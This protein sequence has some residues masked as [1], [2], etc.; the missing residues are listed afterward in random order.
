MRERSTW[1]CQEV[2]TKFAALK[3]A[4]PY[5]MNQEHPQPPWDKYVSGD[6]SA[7]A[8][9][10]HSP[11]TWETEY[12]DDQTARDEIG[13]PQVRPDTFNHTE[14]TASKEVLLK[15]ADLCI[16]VAQLMLKQASTEA[17]EDQAVA[18]MHLPDQELINT[19][20]RM[21][22]DED[23]DKDGDKEQEKQ[24]GQ[25]EDKKD[26]TKDQGQGQEKQAEEAKG[27]K[28]DQNEKSNKNWPAKTAGEMQQMA[29]QVIQQIQA[30][31]LAE[32]QEQI[33]QMVETAQQ[34][35]QA[36]AQAPAQ[37]QQQQAQQQQQS[38]QAQQQQVAQ[39][40]Q[41]MI[42]QAMQQQQAQQ[43]QAPVQAPAQAPVQDQQQQAQQQTPAQ[44]PVQDQQQ[45][46][47]QDAQVLDQM[48]AGCGL[49]EGDIQMDPAPMDVGV[50]D[51]GAED[52]VLRTL[53][54]QDDSQEEKDQ[55]KGQ[56]QEQEKQASIRTAST[57]TVG[58]RPTAGVAKLGGA[59][60][61][62]DN[63]TIESLSA[64]WQT[65]PDVRDAFGIK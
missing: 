16:A 54:A 34:Q 4:D 31:K 2:Q 3:T 41:Q 44:A 30:G 60:A 10:V 11:N 21:A 40:V 12:K 26:D 39:Q 20:K 63:A 47:Q 64:L 28:D 55:G 22:A 7:F 14:K 15:K 50:D 53:F 43:Q 24:A 45:Q 65:A 33:K 35:Q 61:K 56:E 37:D 42:Q 51:L 36:P 17:I 23:D 62:S 25:E 29:Q 9:D 38:Q 6:P 19:H 49:A 18:L 59:G 32:A 1:N 5:T 13:M 52:E 46:A 58:T 48:L 8:E 27:K 57:R